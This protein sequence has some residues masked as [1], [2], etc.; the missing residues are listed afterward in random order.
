[1][2]VEGYKSKA[3]LKRGCSTLKAG[4]FAFALQS[5]CTW[6]GER[7]VERLLYN[8]CADLDEDGKRIKVVKRVGQ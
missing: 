8:F 5:N 1:M 3:I 2:G 7:Y 6:V 4:A